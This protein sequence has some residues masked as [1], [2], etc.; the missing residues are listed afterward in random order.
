MI[1]LDL[2]ENGF[3]HLLL[4]LLINSL[5]QLLSLDSLDLLISLDNPDPV[6]IVIILKIPK[7]GKHDVIIKP[8]ELVDT[9]SNL[10]ESFLKLI[11]TVQIECPVFLNC[12]KV[13]KFT[14]NPEFHE[15]ALG[16]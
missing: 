8:T 12:V 15:A 1:L 9:E 14:R 10:R 13:D 3:L 6:V 2:L 5:G 16:L 7:A 4:P 11:P